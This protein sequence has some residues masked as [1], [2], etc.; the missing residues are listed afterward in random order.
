VN[1]SAFSLSAATLSRAHLQRLRDVYRSAGWPCLDAI[2]LDL[3]AAQLLERI[4]H[5]SGCDTLR[6]TDAGIAYLAQQH[7]T[8]RRKLDAH[9]AL[10]Q[11]VAT[12]MQREGRVVFTRLAVRVA[13]GAKADD[14]SKTQWRIAQPDVFS[15]RNTPVETYAAPIVHEIKVSRADLLSDLRKAH[16]RQAYL[17]LASQCYYVLAEG[18]GSASDVPREFGVWILQGESFEIARP[19]PQTTE[20]KLPYGVWLAL[21]KATPSPLDPDTATAQALLGEGLDKGLL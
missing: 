5:K 7:H 10:V 19:A 18:I 21:A 16:K 8:N 6:V 2:E 12:L 1:A 4:T 14:A 13:A 11:R 17:S 15:L 3:L 9:E 20:R